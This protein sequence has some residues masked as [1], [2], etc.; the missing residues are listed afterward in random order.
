MKPKA[1]FKPLNVQQK[2]YIK[3]ICNLQV[4]KLICSKSIPVFDKCVQ[5]SF[6]GRFCFM[7]CNI[8]IM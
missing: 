2:E 4:N 3:L 5:G 7:L 1:D 6:G 8:S